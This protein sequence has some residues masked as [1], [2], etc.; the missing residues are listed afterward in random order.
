MPKQKLIL[1]GNCQADY[2]ARVLR[3]SQDLSAR[4]EL[5]YFSNFSTPGV[6]D[7]ESC[8]IEE[9]QSC[10]V[11]VYHRVFTPDFVKAADERLAQLPAHCLRFPLPYL[12]SN[13]Y[14]P[15]FNTV[16]TPIGITPKLP[17]G[18][19]P[20]RNHIIDSWIQRGLSDNAIVE[21]FCALDPAEHLDMELLERD[22]YERWRSLE[23]GA[24]G[25]LKFA[26]FLMQNWRGSMLFYVYNHISKPVL[27]HL[28][29]QILSQ[30][31]APELSARDI[32]KCD[33]GQA[34]SYP[35]HPGAARYYGISFA[36]EGTR[37]SLAEN[38]YTFAEFIRFYISMA[39][40]AP[41]PIQL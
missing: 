24:E 13:L 4:F 26:S 39:R 21:A 9:L 40:K 32:A 35:V 31:G 18:L 22:T 17:Y 5:K 10:D 30:L 7:T 23:A 28:A 36:K 16:A 34:V 38:N 19:V 27:L 3:L 1:W 8:P 29:N 11:L 25:K 6:F 15:F 2:L 33:S 41:S 14:W 12:K 20:Y 37:Y